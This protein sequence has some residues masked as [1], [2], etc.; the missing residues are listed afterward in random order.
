MFPTV[1]I[2]FVLVLFPIFQRKFAVDSAI[3]NYTKMWESWMHPDYNHL[4]IPLTS[5]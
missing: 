1:F 4:Y 2:E 3:K 5:K